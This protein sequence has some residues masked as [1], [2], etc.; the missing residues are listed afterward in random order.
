MK[1]PYISQRRPLGVARPAPPSKATTSPTVTVTAALPPP[2]ALLAA[3][4]VTFTVSGLLV[5]DPSDT[6]SRTL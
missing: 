2:P 1:V 5:N 6:T 3:R 4:A